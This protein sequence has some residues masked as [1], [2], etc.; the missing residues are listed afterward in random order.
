MN[1]AGRT[2]NLMGRLRLMYP[3]SRFFER[4]PFKDL[5][6]ITSLA[7]KVCNHG[8]IQSANAVRRMHGYGVRSLGLAQGVPQTVPPISPNRFAFLMLIM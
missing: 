7:H 5:Q 4:Y 8:E 2:Q 3:L 6:T 1:A